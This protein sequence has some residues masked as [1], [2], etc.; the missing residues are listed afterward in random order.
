MSWFR[1]IAS[2]AMFACSAGAAM[3]EEKEEDISIECWKGSYLT[4]FTGHAGH[5][6][7]RMSIICARWNPDKGRLDKPVV[8][9]RGLIGRSDGGDL[10]DDLHCPRGWAVAGGYSYDYAHHEGVEALHHL[11]FNCRPVG[12]DGDLQPLRFGSN[13]KAETVFKPANRRQCADGDLAT[14][15]KARHGEFIHE[16]QLICTRGPSSIVLTKLPGPDAFRETMTSKRK[17]GG[18]IMSGEAAPPP[19]PESTPPLPAVR[20][21]KTT[22]DVDVLEEPDGAK[23]GGVGDFLPARQ[24]VPVLVEK[25][26]WCQLDVK[27]FPFVVGGKGW[28]SATFL[29]SCGK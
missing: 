18:L 3:A 29:E 14:G 23:Y 10:I 5:V 26:G 8:T 22:G 19:P 6:I 27:D 9:T 21:T 24:V 11:D 20:L 12:G 25:P 17:G 7:D 15:V 28:V 2:V 13:S 16:W 4:G 1:W